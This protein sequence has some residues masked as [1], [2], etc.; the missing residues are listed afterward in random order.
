MTIAGRALTVVH[1]ASVKDSLLIMMTAPVRFA[2]VGGRG[3]SESRQK[4]RS[5]KIV[6]NVEHTAPVPCVARAGGV[7]RLAGLAWSN[8]GLGL[9]EAAGLIATG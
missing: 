7:L 8:R 2:G 4:G 5:G 1:S 9:V 3:R 6:L